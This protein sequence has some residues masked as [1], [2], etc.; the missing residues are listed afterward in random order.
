MSLEGGNPTTNARPSFHRKSIGG[1]HG[2]KL[3]YY[4]DYLDNVLFDPETGRLNL[5]G[6]N[7]M[8]TRYVIAAGAIPGMRAVYS[9]DKTG[10]SVYEY[11]DALTRGSLV[12]QSRGMDVG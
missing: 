12:R 2:A 3:R 4:Q 8:N 11:Q 7:I 6:I 5:E 10:I 9:D 1:Y